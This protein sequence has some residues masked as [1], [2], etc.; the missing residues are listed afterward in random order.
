MFKRAFERVNA[1]RIRDRCCW[2]FEMCPQSANPSARAKC[3]F[4]DLRATSDDPARS[5]N[6]IDVEASLIGLGGRA[7]MNLNRTRR[8]NIQH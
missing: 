7:R 2:F 1:E 6:L 3:R 4:S 5:V 8:F